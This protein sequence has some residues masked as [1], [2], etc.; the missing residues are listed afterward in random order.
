M[1]APVLN[2]SDRSLEELVDSWDGEA[3]VM[4]RARSTDA[5]ITIGVHSTALGPAA[6]GCRMR[7]YRSSAAAVEDAHRLATAMTSKLAVC[8]LPFGGG[9]AVLAVP[10]I[11]EGDARRDLL[12]ELG[13]LVES[14]GGLYITAPDMNTSDVD[15]DVVAER[16]SHVF[17]RTAES[18]GCGNPAPAT[19]AGVEAGLRAAIAHVFGSD[20]LDGRRV[21]V[22]GVGAVGE[23]LARRLTDDGADVVVCD[24]DEQRADHLARRIG[25]RAIPAA[26]WLDEECDV[27]APCAAGG[28]LDEGTIPR[29]RCRLVAGAANNQLRERADADRLAAR[30]ITW[31][32]DYVLNSGGVLKGVGME[33]L[34]WPPE[35]VANR[36]Q[37]VGEDVASL[38]R[39]ADT[40]GQTPLAVAETLASDRIDAARATRV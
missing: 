38:L 13:E 39:R 14:L 35:E 3:T 20:D 32:P 19:A 6:G 27:F 23:R 10:S 4:R 40:E 36:L 1:G 8:G 17:C 2:G 15:M 24:I 18:G 5:L 31:V 28:I 7:T 12:L 16:T 9:K 25:V 11:P 26:A 22:Q 30:G 37:Q 29:L 33:L 34:H 21:L